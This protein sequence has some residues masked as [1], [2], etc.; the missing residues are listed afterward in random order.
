MCLECLRIRPLAQRSNMSMNMPWQAWE[1][2]G[3]WV[4]EKTKS[5]RMRQREVWSHKW[6]SQQCNGEYFWEQTGPLFCWRSLPSVWFLVSMDDVCM[7]FIVSIPHYEPASLP[8]QAANRITSANLH[9]LFVMNVL[10][11][12]QTPHIMLLYMLFSL[13]SGEILLYCFI[14]FFIS[15][16]RVLV[17]TLR[18]YDG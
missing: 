13:H 1:P 7:W 15:I 14:T 16:P 12:T 9:V 17:S 6:F 10:C 18:V 2:L 4:D 5:R 11:D 8:L 3:C